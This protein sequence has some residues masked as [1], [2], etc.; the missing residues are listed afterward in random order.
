ME[1]FQT[2]PSF[3]LLPDVIAAFAGPGALRLL[4]DAEHNQNSHLLRFLSPLIPDLLPRLLCIPES[5][6]S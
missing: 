2:F 3:L 4:T 6:F 1:T 5:V